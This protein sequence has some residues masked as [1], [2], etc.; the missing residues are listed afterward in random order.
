MLSEKTDC[1][2]EYAL[3][4]IY[5]DVEEDEKIK[6][7]NEGSCLKLVQLCVHFILENE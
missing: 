5:I 4:R 7:K 1:K 6:H 2:I 3:G